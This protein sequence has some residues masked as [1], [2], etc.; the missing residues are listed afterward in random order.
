V[1]GP[2]AT[3][4]A[5]AVTLLVCFAATLLWIQASARKRRLVGSAVVLLEVAGI[6]FT[7]FRGAW[8]AALVVMIVALGL[9]PRRTGRLICIAVLVGLLAAWLSSQAGSTLS[10]R[11]N[12]P[13][14][15][16]GRAATYPQ[17]L[18]LFVRHPLM[19]VGLGQFGA[20]QASEL[21]VNKVNGVAAVSS[22][23]SSYFDVLSEGGLLLLLPFLAATGSSA[24]M[25]HRYRK[26]GAGDPYDVL[27]GA[28]VAAAALAYVVMSLEETVITSSTASNAFIAIL[29]GACAGRLD[30]LDRRNR[31]RDGP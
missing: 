3:D 15:V 12:N 25:I 29:L 10:Q 26:I 31:V 16:N 20:A 5:L 30:T 21:L 6:G 28:A 7:L 4:D 1:S 24:W 17:A 18:D 27:I 22:P 9:R 13:A 14:D 23:H 2:Y 11:I 19:G 8:I